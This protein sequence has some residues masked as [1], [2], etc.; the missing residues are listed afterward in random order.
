MT[1]AEEKTDML[2][3]AASNDAEKINMRA[4][5]VL[6]KVDQFIEPE[7]RAQVI[8]AALRAA[9]RAGEKRGR[10]EER[11]HWAKWHENRKRLIEQNEMYPA[12]CL[13]AQAMVHGD[14]VEM[15][16][17]ED[18]ITIRARAPAPETTP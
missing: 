16:R 7:A 11:E 10:A 14:M 13:N 1:D 12:Y 9:E 18:E 17:D 4:E 6:D 2:I 5:A 15:L 3:S 8:A